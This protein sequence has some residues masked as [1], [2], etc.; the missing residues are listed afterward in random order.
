VISGAIV[1]SRYGQGRLST[2]QKV[3][4]PKLTLYV[5]V[6]QFF[7]AFRRNHFLVHIPPDM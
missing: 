5:E 6:V 2:F 4:I 7:F 1:S 3:A